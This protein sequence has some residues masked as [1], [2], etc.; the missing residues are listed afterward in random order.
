[1]GAASLELRNDVSGNPASSG[2]AI[3]SRNITSTSYGTYNF[4]SQTPISLSANTTYWLTISYNIADSIG[5][6]SSNAAAVPTGAYA[7]FE[8][9][10][11]GPLADQTVDPNSV[12]PNLFPP[13]AIQINGLTAVPE[14]QSFVLISMLAVPLAF[15]QF[16]SRFRRLAN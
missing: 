6:A 3:T 10:R 7:S 1:L 11:T 13:P 15:Q 9:L 8:G 16:R 4:A 5:V 14:P 12:I 2:I